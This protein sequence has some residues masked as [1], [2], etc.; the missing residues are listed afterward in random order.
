MHLNDLPLS[1][2]IAPDGS[3]RDAVATL[4]T[5]ALNLALEYA[6][7]ALDLPPLPLEPSDLPPTTL[8]EHGLPEGLL[9]DQLRALLVASMHPA[10]PGYIGHMD[11]LPTTMSLVGDLLS[12]A[13]NNNMLSI[14]M[15][16]LLSRLEWNTLRELARLF[17]LG[18]WAGG[19]LLSGGSLA[20]LEALAIAR[21]HSL[22]LS[23][24][25]LVASGLR[26]VLFASEAAHTSLQKAA[27][28]LGLGSQAVIPVPLDST[29][30][31]DVHRLPLLIEEALARGEHPFCLVATAGTTVAGLI[32]PLAR[33]APIARRYGLW[34]HVDAAYGG[35]LIFSERG[36]ALLDGIE[37]ADSVTFNP[38]KWLYVAKTC[39]ALLLRNS[40]LFLQAFRTA[41]PYM[42]PR[43]E[44]ASEEAEAAV[45]CNLGEIA[46]QG[47]RHSD[48]LK[49]WLS[50]Q[51]LGRRGYA[52]L[53]DESCRLAS[54]AYERLRSLPE[55]H[56]AHA[57]ETNLLCFRLEPA[58]LPT[59]RHDQLN[60][61]LQAWLL[62]QE[63]IFLSLPLY[64]G[65]RWLR[66]VFLNPYTSEAL[67]ERL[68]S[69]IERFLAGE[70]RRATASQTH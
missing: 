35:A 20:N 44:P 24:G 38:Q 68:G 16:P 30:H 23:D 40:D 14:E 61:S 49:L 62:E 6:T 29:G 15:S 57:P 51:H 45:P 2:F 41:A 5:Q 7:H 55:L 36:R 32:D 47:T 48:I 26:P 27:M 46:L 4:L 17:G 10:H 3:N 37:Q 8:P 58:W 22:G 65:Q 70:R 19:I 66:A 9:L 43:S 52:R 64:R 31:L 13:L 39:A 28:L 1:A 12:A 21:N 11:S 50:L 54:F 25:A 63:Q 53:V 33:L 60:A 18:E 67:I 34:F 42:G 56:V 59:D 69:A